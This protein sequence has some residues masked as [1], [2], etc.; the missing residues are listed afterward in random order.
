MLN[1]KKY[2]CIILFQKNNYFLRDKSVLK[3]MKIFD[4]FKRKKVQNYP[5]QNKYIA[6]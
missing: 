4:T 6:K 1:C 3:G 2:N 5:F